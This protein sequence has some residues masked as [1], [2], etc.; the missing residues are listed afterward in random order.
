MRFLKTTI[1]TSSL[2]LLSACGLGAQ[3]QAEQ[4]GS[5][6]Y[7]SQ[8]KT[9]DSVNKAEG[10]KSDP[11][12]PTMQVVSLKQADQSETVAQAMDR[13]IIKDAE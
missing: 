10:T 9:H 13:K 7:V 12:A 11:S 5:A 3:K 1:F 4:A 8:A 2:L 6:R